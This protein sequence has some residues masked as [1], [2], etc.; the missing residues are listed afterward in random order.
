MLPSHDSDAIVRTGVHRGVLNHR[1]TPETRTRVFTPNPRRVETPVAVAQPQPVVPVDPSNAGRNRGGR[2]GRGRNWGDRG[3][4]GNV[5]NPRTSGDGR[6]SDWRNRD[7]DGRRGDWRN[8]DRDNDDDDNRRWRDR[9]HTHRR[10]DWDRTHRHRDWWRSRYNRFALFGGGYYYWNSGYWYPAYGYDPYFS[11]YSY[12]APIYSYDNQDPGEVISS[13][14]E[15][16]QERGYY[17]GVVD[18]SFGR[19]TRR[20]LV[21]FQRDSGLSVTGEIDQETLSALGFE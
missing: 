2:D 3:G 8:R 19:L 20:A 12:D 14:Q 1:I 11:T 10:H 15:A 18:G 4:S 9:N 21:E 5:E 13:V 17:R 16:L 6:T 7:G